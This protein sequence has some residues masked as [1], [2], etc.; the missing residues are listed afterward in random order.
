MKHIS[1]RKLKKVFICLFCLLFPLICSA[2]SM[3]V[4]PILLSSKGSALIDWSKMVISVDGVPAD[5][6]VIIWSE[7]NSFSSAWSGLNTKQ[8]DPGDSDFFEYVIP[9]SGLEPPPVWVSTSFTS[10]PLVSRFGSATGHADTNVAGLPVDPMNPI[11]PAD[12]IFANSAVQLKLLGEGDVFIAQAVLE[13]IFSVVPASAADNTPRHL[14]VTVPYQLVQ[15]LTSTLVRSAFSDV[16]VSLALYDLNT[17]DPLTGNSD[18]LTEATDSLRKE[19][20]SA[21]TRKVHY[22]IPSTPNTWAT[23]TL[24]YDVYPFSRDQNG[25]ILTDPDGN[26]IPAIYDFEAS[27]ST[28]AGAGLPLFRGFPFWWWHR[29]CVK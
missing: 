27:A 11:A 24:E 14:I 18:L 17:T 15:D 7:K 29:V 21:F 3:A 6:R 10:A 26:P 8:T 25:I 16:T 9:D 2:P 13:G 5:P 12:R 23:L 20:R 28:V 4:D 19:F 1:Y 22:Q